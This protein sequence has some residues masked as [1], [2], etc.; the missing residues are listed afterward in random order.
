MKLHGVLANGEVSSNLCIARTARNPYE[1]LAFTRR[2]VLIEHG[3]PLG[4]IQ[5]DL[6]REV[7]APARGRS[8]A[9]CPVEV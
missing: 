3:R 6:D 4:W 8:D 9:H 5:G 7:R 1:D 2:E